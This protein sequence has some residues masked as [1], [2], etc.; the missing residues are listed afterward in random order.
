MTHRDPPSPGIT[1]L[2]VDDNAANRELVVTLLKYQGHRTYEAGDGREALEIAGAV[3]PQ[4]V[5]SDIVMPTMDGFEFV[6]RLRVN[7]ELA[8]TKVIFYT[9]HFHGR[10]AHTLAEA[11]QVS[12]VITKPCEPADIL[13]AIERVL[14][15]GVASSDSSEVRSDFDHDH[16]QLVT[17]KLAEKVDQLE[18][19]NARL[20]ALTDLNLELASERD[21]QALLKNICYSARRLLGAKYAV[22]AAHDRRDP[23]TLYFYTSGFENADK[24]TSPSSPRT[25]PGPLGGVYARRSPWRAGVGSDG[26]VANPLPAGYPAGKS[27]LAVPI[28]S[29]RHAYG[30]LC[31]QDKIGAEEFTTEDER[32]LGILAAQVGRIYENGSLYHQIQIH[33]AQLRGL[34]RRLMEVED[35]ERRRINR[36]LH[37]RVGQSLS[38][39]NLNLD[40]IRNGLET[41][42]PKVALN[43]R[44]D[45]A[46]TLL[47][48]TVTDIRDLMAELHPPALDDYGLFAALRSYVES[49]RRSTGLPLTIS[50]QDLDPPLPP[51]AALAL[52]RVAQG[53]LTNAAKHAA[54]SH[55]DVALADRG[56]AVTLTIADD[57]RGFDIRGD[58]SGAPSWGLNILRERAEAVGATL[59]IDSRPGQGTQVAVE[60]RRS[61]W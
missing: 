27:Y 8:K 12:H 51:V 48:T 58:R 1:V 61:S 15:G 33:A 54:A 28:N 7:P 16:L 44:L 50:G 20:K 2:V 35:A 40:L 13:N 24:L 42:S 17:N 53:A 45:T 21:P 32:I 41:D 49:L 23:D 31:L 46:Q 30:W 47:E 22:L 4:L 5:I 43:T 19:A 29:L 6:R 37:D 26:T 18:S 25:D 10:E 11:C 38:A 52:F 34:S 55:I 36:E 39:L 14:R 3:R 57:G 9:A 56:D 59:T 60:A